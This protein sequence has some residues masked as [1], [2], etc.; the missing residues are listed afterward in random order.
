MGTGQKKGVFFGVAVF[1]LSASLRAAEVYAPTIPNPAAEPWRWQTLNYPEVSDAESFIQTSDGSIWAGENWVISRYDGHD[2]NEF[3]TEAPHPHKLAKE[4]DG[5]IY[6]GDKRNIYQF[7]GKDKWTPIINTYD[8]IRAIT[9]PKSGELWVHVDEGVIQIKDNKQTLWLPEYPI[10]N[11]NLTIPNAETIDYLGCMTTGETIKLDPSAYAK[12]ANT[13]TAPPLMLNMTDGQNGNVWIISNKNKIY[14]AQP[15]SNVHWDV[16]TYPRKLGSPYK[17]KEIM[18]ASDGTLWII[19]DTTHN[20]ILRFDPIR[21]NWQSL[22]PKEG[23]NSP[24]LSIAQTKDQT[25]WISC[26]DRLLSYTKEKWNSI[27]N[28]NLPIF[29]TRLLQLEPGI[30]HSLWVRSNNK[31]LGRLD[32]SGKIW[33][34]YEELHFQCSAPDGATWFIAQDG[35][36]VRRKQKQW[37]AFSVADGLMDDPQK[38]ISTRSGQIWAAGSHKDSAATAKL[39]GARWEKTEHP[40]FSKTILHQSCFEDQDGK[41]WFGAARPTKKTKSGLLQYDPTTDEFHHFP[42]QKTGSWHSWGIAQD[43]DGT[44][45]S[46]GRLKRIENDEFKLYLPEMISKITRE[47]HIIQ[48]SNSIWFLCPKKG[49]FNLHNRTST[50]YGF[51]HAIENATIRNLLAEGD[52]ELWAAM[53]QGIYF[54]DGTSWSSR[55]LH[56]SLA[57]SV[58]IHSLQRGREND[59]WVNMTSPDGTLPLMESEHNQYKQSSLTVRYRK[60]N[61]KPDTFF[62]ERPTGKRAWNE[63]LLFRW[64]GRD[65]WNTPSDESLEF[66]YKLNNEP[67]SPFHSD[68]HYVLQNLSVGKHRF[69]VRARNRDLNIDPSPAV[70]SFQIIGPLWKRPWFIAM[71]CT[72]TGIIFFLIQKLTRSRNLRIQ[73]QLNFERE[74]AKQAQ[75]LNRFR[76]QFFTNISHELRTPLTLIM[77]P[78]EEALKQTRSISIKEQLEMAKRNAVRLQHLVNQLLDMRKLQEGK[79]KLEVAE[80]NMIRFIQDLINSFASLTEK[81]AI[82][83]H[84]EPHEEQVNVQFDADKMNKVLTNLLSNA[85]KFTPTNGNICIKTT[86][87]NELFCIRIEDSGQG[88]DQEYQNLI[89]ERFAQAPNSQSKQNSSGI[90]LAFTK[91]L[92]EL[93]GGLITVQSPL[94]PQNPNAKG[95][96]FTIHIPLSQTDTELVLEK[97]E[98]TDKAPTEIA[99]KQSEQHHVLIVDDNSDMRQFIRNG[100]EKHFEIIEAADGKQGL[101]QAL[102]TAPD[103]IVSDV[104]M[105]KMNGYELCKKLKNNLQTSHIPLILLTAKGSTDAQIEG[106][107][108]GANDYIVKPFNMKLLLMRIHNLLDIRDKLQQKFSNTLEIQPAELTQSAADEDFL[109]KAISAIIEHLDMADLDSDMLA[110][111]IGI[112]RSALYPKIKAISGLTVHAFI[113][114]VRLKQ[115]AKMLIQGDENIGEVS[116]KTGF[117]SHA[118]FSKCFAKEFGKTPSE[119]VKSHKK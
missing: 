94:Y 39:S 81:K 50:R 97:P 51:F 101:S 88:I 4:S 15:K 7:N 54:F 114:S 68:Q 34:S 40:D 16:F 11:K 49:L 82:S 110:A 116:F 9:I 95:T 56:K 44:I 85:V 63:A 57:E 12:P 70:V 91:E 20:S 25:I 93:H 36:V 112:S 105:P 74:Q 23:F 100:L 80:D 71:I 65:P 10:N 32:L 18:E 59:L 2:W 76:V 21:D 55:I 77:G 117:S 89:F 13:S 24:C 98:K 99:A 115:A 61:F 67:W 107:E 90:G 47:V 52:N 69:S 58:N 111:Q 42:Y 64:E 75:K 22:S 46:G 41:L 96:A 6:V 109:Q 28:R 79:L 48:G 60:P 37:T 113:R 92:V 102:E 86:E 108:T 104:M 53:N 14:R 106:L 84:F 19:R 45:Y 5:R 30:D 78:L 3:N 1:S 103:L 29:K 73:E 66:S 17:I 43:V 35:R 62:K 8:V 33:N 72:F 118:Y 119:F 27:Y 83:I 38:I 87:K 26:A 31:G